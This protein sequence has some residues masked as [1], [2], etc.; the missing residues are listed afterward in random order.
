[1]FSSLFLNNKGHV[2]TDLCLTSLSHSGNYSG[3]LVIS[4][5]TCLHTV[6]C[7]IMYL[8]MVMKLHLLGKMLETR[9]K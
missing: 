7:L 3:R 5:S 4:E 1:M 6:I 8:P 9:I 2:K